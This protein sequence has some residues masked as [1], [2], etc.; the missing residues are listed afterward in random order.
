[1]VLPLQQGLIHPRTVPLTADQVYDSMGAIR[2]QAIT[3]SYLIISI[4]DI[5]LSNLVYNYFK[6]LAISQI[7]VVGYRWQNV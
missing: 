2:I 5:Y 3:N 1:M 7:L 6:C 4:R